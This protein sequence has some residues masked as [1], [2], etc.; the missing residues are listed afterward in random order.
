MDLN[1]QTAKDLIQK[2]RLNQLSIEEVRYFESF[3]IDKPGLIELIHIDDIFTAHK[4]AFSNKVFK[5]LQGVW[6]TARHQW[7]GVVAG[8]ILGAVMVIC[9]QWPFSS[10]KTVSPDLVYLETY[11][12]EIPDWHIY[13]NSAVSNKLLVIDLGLQANSEFQLSLHDEKNNR[14]YQ[15]QQINTNDNGELIFEIKAENVQ[16][17]R[18]DMTISRLDK[19]ANDLHYTL[20]IDYNF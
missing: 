1:E 14:D 10:D 9:I 17:G 5:R 11:R 16:P 18:Y 13:F 3:L 12:G 6:L 15:W 2:Y 8:A 19:Q 7:S 4:T 20:G